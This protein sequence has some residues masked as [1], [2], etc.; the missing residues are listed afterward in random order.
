MPRSG[1]HVHIVRLEPA[2][3]STA[4]ISSWPLTPCSRNTATRGR[5]PAPISG[6]AISAAGRSSTAVTARIA[7]IEQRR[8]LLVRA[9]RIITQPAHTVGVS[10]QARRRSPQASSSSVAPLRI[11]NRSCA[12]A[13]RSPV[14]S[15]RGRGSRSTQ[16]PLAAAIAAPA[17]QLP[18]PRR[19]AAPASSR[20]CCGV[21][22]ERDSDSAVT[23]KCH[24]GQCDQQ[25]AVG[26]IVIASTR[27]ARAVR[28]APPPD[29]QQRWFVKVRMRATAGI[30]NLRQRT[31]AETVA[32][33]RQIEQQQH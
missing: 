5:A 12:A 29:R 21:G 27:R 6:A 10:D 30:E 2:R 9:L 14:H 7:L 18:A 25:A 4:A 19:T 11:C 32:A 3:S 28:S 1:R 24:L 22:G 23:G 13:R 20:R 16:A 33:T 17:A 15:R 26:A 31:H 8:Q